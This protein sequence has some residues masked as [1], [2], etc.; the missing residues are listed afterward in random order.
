MC[1]CACACVC[2]YVGV[3]V[4][5]DIYGDGGLVYVY[6]RSYDDEDAYDLKPW[7]QKVC[8]CRYTLPLDVCVCVCV[9]IY[10]CIHVSTYICLYIYISAQGR[11]TS[12]SRL[13][14]YWVKSKNEFFFDTMW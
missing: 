3:C 6:R 4:C 10:A 12:F 8:R 1:V 9:Y 13:L 7:Q 14:F 5:A 11:K 2:V